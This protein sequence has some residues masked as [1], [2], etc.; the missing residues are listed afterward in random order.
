M[1]FV[2]H[3]IKCDISHVI[4]FKI[5]G[6][7]MKK[8]SL[9]IS[10]EVLGLIELNSAEEALNLYRNECHV[11]KICKFNDNLSYCAK[12]CVLPRMFHLNWIDPNESTSKQI[13]IVQEKFDDILLKL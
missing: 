2:T 12:L 7:N 8:N 10:E 13:D 4:Y 5:I 1:I 3:L 11:F 9:V 6:Y